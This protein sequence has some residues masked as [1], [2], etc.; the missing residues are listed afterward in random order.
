[1]KAQLVYMNMGFDVFT[2]THNKTRADFI[3]VNGTTVLR[4][5]VK[6]AQYNGAYIQA[7]LDVNGEKYTKEDCDIIV[8]ILDENVW[9][10]PIEEVSGM[11][12]ICLGKH[13]DPEYKPRKEYD[14]DKWK[15]HG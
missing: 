15:M 4:V 7:R 13:G 5:Q 11:S 9:I 1:M 10:C 12:S 8:F 14:P 3:A 2:P 6:T